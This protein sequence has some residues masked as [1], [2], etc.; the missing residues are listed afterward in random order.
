MGIESFSEEEVAEAIETLKTGK[1]P[2]GI[3][4]NP[5][6]VKS[7]YTVEPDLLRDAGELMAYEMRG[8]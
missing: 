4:M 5:E 1:P 3:G 8:R 7:L 6:A 2:V